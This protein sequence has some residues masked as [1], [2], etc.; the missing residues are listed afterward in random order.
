[1]H[2]SSE[3]GTHEKVMSISPFPM[4][5]FSIKASMTLRLSS[6]AKVGHWSYIVLASCITSS[7]D[8][9]GDADHDPQTV[10]LPLPNAKAKF[11]RVL[12]LP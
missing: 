5:T 4:V 9:L 6:M 11:Y 8:N 1:L 2:T 7:A 10:S 12:E 3:E